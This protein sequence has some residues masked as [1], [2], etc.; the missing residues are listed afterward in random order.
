MHSTRRQLW[1]GPSVK[2]WRALREKVLH[3]VSFFF[4]NADIEALLGFDS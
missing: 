2:R 4:K 3:L 1:I